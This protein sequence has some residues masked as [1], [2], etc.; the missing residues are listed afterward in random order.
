MRSALAVAAVAAC[1]GHVTDIQPTLQLADRS[2]AELARLIAAAHGGDVFA[3]QAQLDALSGSTDPCPA[4]AIA[5]GRIEI[6]GGCT[7]RGGDA[8]AGSATVMNPQIWDAVAYDFESDTVYRFDRLALGQV[9]YD[10]YVRI[11]DGATT[12]DADLTVGQYGVAVRS[13]LF[14]A[15]DHTSPTCSLDG[16]GLELV[17]AGGVHVS[18]SITARRGQAS[19]TL[20]GLD[21]L[22][23]TLTGDC[24]AWQISGSDRQ[25]ACP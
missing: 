11:S 9:T 2:D 22:T 21:T 8:I 18:G 25:Q 7:T 16:S 6:T 23:A 12:Y 1:G 17:G 10:G 20:R 4:I 24:T 13:D 3:A 14:Y 19:F 15:C 5:G